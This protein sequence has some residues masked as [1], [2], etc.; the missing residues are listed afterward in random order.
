LAVK[1]AVLV[2]VAVKV[3][4]MEK[5]TAAETVRASAQA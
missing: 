4:G 3:K 2:K 5:A 1:A